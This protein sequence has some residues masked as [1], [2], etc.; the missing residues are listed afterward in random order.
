MSLEL[1]KMACPNCGNCDLDEYNEKVKCQYCQSTFI[2]DRNNNL[3]LVS[4]G[5][6]TSCPACQKLTEDKDFCQYCGEQIRIH[7]IVCESK[8]RRD[9]KFCPLDGSS[10]K[11]VGEISTDFNNWYCDLTASKHHNP[12]PVFV[13]N[14]Q[15]ILSERELN[16]KLAKLE[17]AQKKEEKLCGLILPVLIAVIII[18]YLIKE[19]FR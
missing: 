3:I 16:S 9:V 1:K 14:T 15:K 13:E 7:C 11:V 5:N 18:V 19:F 12:C 6:M 2:I 10:I 4:M 8:H 17:K